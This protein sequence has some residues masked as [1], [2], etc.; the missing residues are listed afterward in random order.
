MKPTEPTRTNGCASYLHIVDLAD[1]EPYDSNVD[2]NKRKELED[3]NTSVSAISE[4]LM[5]IRA[6]SS[7]IPYRRSGIIFLL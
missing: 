3:V 4:V 7:H 5:A 2:P 6:R 1:M